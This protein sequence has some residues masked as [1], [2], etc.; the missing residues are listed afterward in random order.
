M[1]TVAGNL[2][3]RRLRKSIIRILRDSEL[4]SMATLDP[5]N[6]PHINTAYF[7]YKGLDDLELFFLSDINS[8]HCR[9]LSRNPSLAMTIFRTNQPWDAPGR[10]IQ[11]FGTC[12]QTEGKLALKA[13]QVYAKR[14]PPYAKWMSS[15]KKGEKKLAEQLRSYRFCRFLPRQLKVLDEE[16]YGGAVFVM[17]TIKR[18]NPASKTE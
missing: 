2:S 16:E 12:S 4:C 15:T 1:K 7:C 9:N 18:R 11:L 5:R 8:R 3:D 6:R 14:F 13:E 17:V 10:G